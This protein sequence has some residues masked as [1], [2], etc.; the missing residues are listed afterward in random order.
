EPA[1]A[2]TDHAVTPAPRAQRPPR[3]PAAL[4]PHAALGATEQCCGGAQ[5]TESPTGQPWAG[6]PGR[7]AHP[8]ERLQAA[9]PVAPGRSSLWVRWWLRRKRCSR[10]RFPQLPQEKGFSP[11][12]MRW[13]VSRFCFRLKLF[14]HTSLNLFPQTSQR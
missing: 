14:W 3:C 12:W 4:S 2:G 11:L 7:G 9:A 10:K 5:G 6:V 8:G 1:V 13:W